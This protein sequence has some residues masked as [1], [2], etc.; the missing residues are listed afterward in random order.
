MPP[1]VPPTGGEIEPEPEPEPETEKEKEKETEKEEEGQTSGTGTGQVNIE[2]S[3]M[4]AARPTPTGRAAGLLPFI[5]PGAG[6]PVL[7]FGSGRRGAG[8]AMLREGN[9]RVVQ[10]RQRTR[11][12]ADLDTGQFTEM[13]IGPPTGV[14]IT[15]KDQTAPAPH[16]RLADTM[17][18]TPG[19]TW[20]EIFPRA[21]GKTSKATDTDATS[22]WEGGRSAQGQNPRSIA[23]EQQTLVTHDLD[24]GLV[25][26]QALGNPMSLR[27]VSS[28][29]DAPST[30]RKRIDV[31]EVQPTASGVSV[32]PRSSPKISR[33]RKRGGN[34]PKRSGKKATAG[35][36]ASATGGKGK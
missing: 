33:E 27:V 17:E 29:S 26:E 24:E 16:V 34:P 36:L 1:E 13:A 3:A 23:W 22:A 15:M 31:M 18:V 32:R 12:V 30:D 25:T 9:P 5:P 2:R 4:S 21:S 35:R 8:G 6:V 28:D 14:I 11:I 7:P 19:E 10:W 20:V